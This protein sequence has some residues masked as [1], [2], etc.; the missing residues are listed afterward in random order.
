[1]QTHK[2]M[3]RS[4]LA[5]WQRP[6]RMMRRDYLADFSGLVET[7][8][9]AM[10]R[11]TK[12]K[13][14][15]NCEWIMA[16][17]G[18]SPGMGQFTTFNTPNFEKIPGLGDFD[19]LRSY[20]PHARR[21]GIKLVPYINLH[22]YSYDFA[23]KHPGWEQL[24]EDGTPYGRK[25]PLYGNGTTFCINS[26]WRDWA[27]A[28][29]REVMATG[30]DGCFLDGPG[31]F[32]KC[33][34]CA[35]C[36]KLFGRITRQK[37]MPSF[38]DWSDPLWKQFLEF[39]V[40]SLVNFLRGAQAAVHAVNPKGIV[41]KNG[42]GYDSGCMVGSRDI[43]RL[44]P[45]QNFTSA[46]QFYHTSEKWDS[47]YQTLNMAR[48]LSAGKNPA[49]VFTHHTLSTWHYI[50]LS[51]AEMTSAIA[52]TVAGG[53][54]P[55]F[56]I[57]ME[58]MPSRAAEAFEAVN[59]NA[60]LEQNEMHFTATEPAAEIAVLLSRHTAFY[61]RSRLKALAKMADSGKEQNLVMERAEQANRAGLAEQRKASTSILDNEYM[62]CLDA[63]TFSHLPARVLW[64][65]HITLKQLM[66]VRILILPGTACL[67]R[68]QI[69]VLAQYVK[70]GGSLIATFESG[71]YDELGQP[72][73]RPE[74]LKLL[75]IERVEG[76]F[77]PSRK[78][79]YWT[80]VDDALPAFPKNIL[81][82]RPLNGLKV[83]A[84]R[85][86]QELVR[87][88]NTLEHFYVNLQGLSPYPAAIYS[89]FGRGRVVY[90]AAPLFESFNRFHLA[91]FRI[92][93]RALIDLVTGKAGT[94]I[95]CKAPGS[96]AV[97]LRRRPG[98]LQV[99][100]INVTS[101]MKRPMENIIRLAN[102]RI[103][104]RASG[105]KR[106]HALRAGKELPYQRVGNKVV[107]TMPEVDVY[108]V[109]IIECTQG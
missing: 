40:Q 55:W 18:C 90:V 108:E 8:L 85:G 109:V 22:W 98:E 101:D 26:P 61:Y 71:F 92:L 49:V 57:F 54:N 84:I 97:E 65:E 16:T 31:I 68:E 20:L 10:A 102:I 9:A 66:S 42:G 91:D 59:L 23:A 78:E 77:E 39:R 51:P 87:Y 33:C 47:P 13:W 34:Y 38:G 69:R 104:V 24:L 27:F 64:D 107:F 43:A 41:F 60:F 100:L 48:F 72:A 94:Q 83:R 35:H 75:G 25:R 21:H 74:W 89:S 73:E 76:A 14:H 105:V 32:P 58:S 3:K 17:P 86:R 36:R 45:H 95:E 96:L 56:A 37:K 29:I 4:R 52:Q 81:L 6:V 80:V 50:P 46:E 15:V 12:E 62:G 30:V 103:A 63:L 11:E 70:N 1:M 28:L 53:A 44:A 93:I 99:H 88:N 106:V 7:D 79:E 2:N 67:S 5:W 19:L 82:P